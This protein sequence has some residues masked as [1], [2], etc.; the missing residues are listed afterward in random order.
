MKATITHPREDDEFLI[1]EGCAVLETWN[2]AEDR[3]VSIARARVA[4]GVRTLPHSLDG[5]V[6]RYLII[7]GTG[8]AHIEGLAPEAVGPG[9]AVVIPAGAVQWIENTGDTDLVFYAICTPRFRMEAYHER[10]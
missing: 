5:I 3:D 9:D 8:I 10:D 2:R 7:L 4:A 1:P 6:E